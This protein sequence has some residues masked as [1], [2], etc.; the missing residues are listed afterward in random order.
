MT[1]LERD[2][3]NWLCA[4]AVPDIQLRSVYS[5]LLYILYTTNYT[6]SLE[7]DVNRECDGHDFIYQYGYEH[8]LQNS[9]MR[10]YIQREGC[11]ILEMMVALAFRMEVEILADQD[12]G[13]RV[14]VWFWNMIRSLDLDGQY[15]KAFDWKYVTYRLQCFENRDYY[16]NGKY[17]LFTISNPNIDMRNCEIWWQM[18]YYIGELNDKEKNYESQ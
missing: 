13:N 11:S 9:F 3:Y 4:K 2:Y 17:G 6:P 12:K 8:N 18:M 16:A 5:N 1:S 14:H 10:D 15:D 7:K